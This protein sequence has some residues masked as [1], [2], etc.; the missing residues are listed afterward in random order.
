MKWLAISGRSR[1]ELGGCNVRDDGNHA[2][3]H[4][5][6]LILRAIP[7]RVVQGVQDSSDSALGACA[8]RLR[9]KVDT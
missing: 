4:R 1:F 8:T 6:Y 5:G 7:G 9:R 2:T 3:V